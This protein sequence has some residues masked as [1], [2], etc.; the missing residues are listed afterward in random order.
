VIYTLNADTLTRIRTGWLDRCSA[1]TFEGHNLNRMRF[2][3]LAYSPYF[4]ARVDH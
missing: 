2:D 4:Y 1:V 3:N